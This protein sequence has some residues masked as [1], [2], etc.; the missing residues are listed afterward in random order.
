MNGLSIP[1]LMSQKCIVNKIKLLIYFAFMRPTITTADSCFRQQLK[2]DLRR[3]VY[4]LR[5]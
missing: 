2:D 5:I 4:A 1:T 3:N